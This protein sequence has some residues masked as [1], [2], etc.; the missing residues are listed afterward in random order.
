MLLVGVEML[1]RFLGKCDDMHWLS[2]GGLHLASNHTEALNV[3][4]LLLLSGKDQALQLLRLLCEQGDVGSRVCGHALGALGSHDADP[5][6][7][8]WHEVNVMHRV[9][10]K[11][12]NLLLSRRGELVWLQLKNVPA[13][14][15]ITARNTAGVCRVLLFAVDFQVCLQIV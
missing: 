8:T 11:K 12:L 5:L 14:V 3:L 9:G 10:D 7:G 15:H 4:C 13:L 1:Q 6:A 2:L